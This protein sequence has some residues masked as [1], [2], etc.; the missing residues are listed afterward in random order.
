MLTRVLNRKTEEILHRTNLILVVLINLLEIFL[1]DELEDSNWLTLAV[2]S[3]LSEHWLLDSGAISH[4]FSSVTVNRHDHDTVDILAVCTIINGRLIIWQTWHLVFPYNGPRMIN[5]PRYAHHIRKFIPCPLPELSDE[6]KLLLSWSQLLA[7][8][9]LNLFLL[10]YINLNVFFFLLE[11]EE[12]IVVMVPEQYSDRIETEKSRQNLPTVYYEIRV[13]ALSTDNTGSLDCFND[14]FL[15]FHHAP[16][17]YYLLEFCLD[18][19]RV[20]CQKNFVEVAE[21]SEKFALWILFLL[22]ENL[23]AG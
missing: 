22:W 6:V 13:A 21:A 18:K 4:H 14:F 23:N 15:G 2:I 17:C 8:T 11:G 5:L 19:N 1:V 3:C 9:L 10:A 20:D 16:L 7:L 12:L